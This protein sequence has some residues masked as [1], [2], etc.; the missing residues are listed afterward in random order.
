M[1]IDNAFQI[2]QPAT[3]HSPPP[4]AHGQ[5]ASFISGD[6]KCPPAETFALFL[7]ACE[8]FRLQPFAVMFVIYY[9]GQKLNFLFLQQPRRR[10]LSFVYFGSPFSVTPTHTYIHIC[11][12]SLLSATKFIVLLLNSI[13]AMITKRKKGQGQSRGDSSRWRQESRHQTLQ[14]LDSRQVQSMPKGF[15]ILHP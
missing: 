10:L 5:S 1:A 9:S 14:T 15:S 6:I 3:P 8:P 4:T 12:A 13:T 7:F 11:R 2:G